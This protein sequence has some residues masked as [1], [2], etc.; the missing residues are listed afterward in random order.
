MQ[1]KKISK[2]INYFILNPKLLRKQA[3]L[4]KYFILILTVIALSIFSLLNLKSIVT[5]YAQLEEKDIEFQQ[6]YWTE[7]SQSV[8]T[9]SS[10]QIEPSTTTDITRKIEKE[11]EPGEGISTLAIEL[12]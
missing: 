7:S 2:N 10:D 6:S 8:S 9:A 5:V 4:F 3:N 12:S 1:N 11:V